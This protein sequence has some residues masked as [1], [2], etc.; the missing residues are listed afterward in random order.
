MIYPKDQYKVCVWMITDLNLRASQLTAY[1][2]IYAY[3]T[4]CE[5]YVNVP[6]ISE[7]IG[8]SRKTVVYAL[9]RLEEKG[10][11]FLGRDSNGIPNCATTCATALAEQAPC[12]YREVFCND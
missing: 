7:M 3:T 10:L 9:E 11:V 12:I 5:N 8:R 4:P 6:F 1:A 2:V